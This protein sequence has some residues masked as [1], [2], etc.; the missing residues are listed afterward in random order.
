M[1][2]G[3]M[4]AIVAIA[5]ACAG[6]AL[7][8]LALRN[9][10]LVRLGLRN[11][12]RRRAR[13]ALIVTG[14]MLGTAIIAAALVTGDT[15]SHTVRSTAVRALGATDEVVAARGAAEDLPGDLGAAVGT[16]YFPAKVVE[17]IDRAARET[18]VVD[19]VTGGILEVVAVQAPRSQRTEPSVVLF[20]PDPDRLDGFGPIED[21]AGS[22]V[23][24][25]DL[26][27][28]QL[29]LNDRAARELDA[30]AGDLLR[31]F[32]GPEPADYRVAAVVRFE[33]T[34]TADAA[35]LVP[36]R[37]AQRLLDRPG[38]VMA[39]FVSNDGG[40]MSGARHSDTVLAALEPV[41][42]GLDLEVTPIKRDAIETADEVGAA[43]MSLFTSLG[44]FSIAAGIL[45]IFLIFVMLAAERRGELGIA[46]AIGTR[47]GHLVQMFVFEGAAYDV[48]AALVGAVLGAVVAY[49][50]V[51]VMSE[52]FGAADAD[53]G[54]QVSYAVTPRSLAVAVAIGILLTL[55]VVAFS[56][57]RVSVM[58]ISSAIRNLPEPLRLRSRRRLVLSGIGLLL[59]LLLAASGASGS[60]ATPLMIGLSLAI[61]SLAPLLRSVGVPER[62]AF[63]V[64]GLT[65]VVM[66][67]LPWRAWEAVFGQLAMDVST[68]I[69]TGLMVVVGIVWVIVYNADLLL[70][71]SARILGRVPFLGPIMRISMAYPLASRFRTGMTLAMFTLVVY[72]LVTMTV[73]PSSFAAAFG[74]V[75]KM[76][77]GFDVR[78]GTTAAAPISDLAVALDQAPGFDRETVTAT[79]SQSVLSVEAE[80]LG[81]GRPPEFYVARGLDDG[82]L[83]HTTF[84]FGAFATGYTSS[85]Q[86]WDALRSNEGLAVVDSMIVERRDN[87]DFAAGLPDFR[88]TGFAFEDGRFDPVRVA[89]NDPQTGERTTLT[90]IGVLA[91]TAPFEMIGLSTSQATLERVFPGRV[92]P[93]IHYFATA[94]GVNPDAAAGELEEAFLLHGLDAESIAAVVDEEMAAN[95]MFNRLM[96]GFMGLGLVVGVA[97]LGVISA[98][99]VVERRQQIGVLRALGF[100]R[101]MVQAAFLLESTFLALTSIVV[102]LALGLVL[103]YDIVDDTRRQSSWSGMSLVV[104]W[105]TLVVVFAI[106]L[107]VAL[108]TTLAP[109]LRASRIPPAQALRYQ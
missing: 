1:P 30:T 92:A 50:M 91:E 58:T 73:L 77:G 83:A 59:G 9:P 53:A 31:V 46:R 39:I 102:G 94:P 62:L 10:I 2:I 14:L 33:G 18:G 95:R 72:T 49:A 93:T 6:A 26:E 106:V 37:E 105:G 68:W 85:R 48:V 99:A 81:A 86:V 80:Q 17:E 13:T 25:G 78:A 55:V 74:T 60:S 79:G 82:F 109:A 100:R 98:R 89:V 96:Q 47:R 28:G 36:L 23:A 101:G 41:A 108:A 51:L 90:V 4:L 16:R 15:M 66:L 103:G 8:V 54:L 75:D 5:V 70:P 97:A 52:A 45:L 88:I 64:C 84:E 21:E 69:M 3:T 35:A 29:L 67:S 76:G 32:A 44:S 87:F 22:P 24:L 40:T 43:F 61:V 71:L 34:G 56:A 107:V 65:V 38:K 7:L 63:T 57:W 12:P 19:G 27:P 11:V 20:A 42:A 104:P